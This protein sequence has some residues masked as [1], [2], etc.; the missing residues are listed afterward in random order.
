ME[1]KTLLPTTGNLQVES[2]LASELDETLKKLDPKFPVMRQGIWDAISSTNKDKARHAIASSR[3]LLSQAIDKLAGNPPGNHT[4]KERIRKILG[5]KAESELVD[6]VGNLVDKV[7][8]LS[9]SGA[10][11]GPSVK[12]AVLC[13]KM[14]EYCLLFILSQS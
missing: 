11:T 13:A 4:R 6:A 12:K 7:Y 10:H 1:E 14:T 3:E 9:S 8:A 5:S 2:E